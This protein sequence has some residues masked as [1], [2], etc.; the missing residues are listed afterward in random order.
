[1]TLVN[2]SALTSAAAREAPIFL[3]GP[4]PTVSPFLKINSGSVRQEPPARREYDEVIRFQL[5]QTADEVSE[6]L[7][8]FTICPTGKGLQAINGLW[9]KG[10]R[11]LGFATG[12]GA[13]GS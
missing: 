13:S 1:M 4:F 2:A 10:V 12:N 8:V 9:A 5:K 3:R 7:K 6:A 11:V